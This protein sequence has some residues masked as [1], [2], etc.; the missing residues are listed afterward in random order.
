MRYV[1][2]AT[3]LAAAAFAGCGGD[4]AASGRGD[5]GAG[6]AAA[7][8][9]AQ[10]TETIKIADFVYDPT[11][12]EVKAGQKI[13]APNADAAPHTITDADSP[14][15]FDSG[16]IKGKTTGS[17]TIDKPGTY[18]YFCEFHPFMKGEITVTR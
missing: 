2:L 12:A 6:A 9:A 11:P 15:A 1:I 7:T 17:F 18:R 14:R 10:P 3:S 16:T 4:D 8:S 13:S 5:T